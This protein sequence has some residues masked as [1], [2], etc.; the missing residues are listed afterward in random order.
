MR[1]AAPLQCTA[2][3]GAEL[4]SSIRRTVCRGPQAGSAGS[5]RAHLPTLQ[6]YHA[7]CQFAR[8]KVDSVQPHYSAQ[9]CQKPGSQVVSMTRLSPSTLTDAGLQDCNIIDVECYPHAKIL[10]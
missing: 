4:T 5:R 2:G 9:H 1:L 10:K 3:P 8:H 7:I 6:P